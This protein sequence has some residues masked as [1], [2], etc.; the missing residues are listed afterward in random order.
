MEDQQIK[1]T[2][3]PVLFA[4]CLFLSACAHRVPPAGITGTGFIDINTFCKKHNFQYSLDT[5]NDKVKLF[6][7]GR[8]I[9]LF[10]NSLAGYFNGNV[11]Y[12]EKAPL[13]SQ[14]K[15]YLPLEL[16]DI[17][18]SGGEIS[19]PKAQFAI[20]TV[21]VDPGHG[22]R[23]PGAVSR[24]GCK[25]KDIN[26]QVS[27]Y[28]KEEL[29]KKG[30]NVILTRSKDIY[31]TLEER[32]EI[33]KKHKADIFI[34]IHANSNRSRS[35]K[36]TEVYYLSPSQ[37]DSQKRAVSLAKTTNLWE[38]SLPLEVRTILWDLCLT[39]NYT[40]S[41][42]LSQ[43]L[44]STF[45]NLGFNVKQ[46]KKAAF[47]VLKNAYVPS[48]LVEMGYLSNTYEE[49]TLRQ[50]HYQKKIAQAVAIG[51]ASLNKRYTVVSKKK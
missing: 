51:A 48:I 50:K 29:E 46:P 47:Y 24:R 8:E 23:D 32:V 19:I 35:I 7:K 11:F 20:R 42:E 21:V 17:I 15:I 4:L 26:L 43:V 36:G 14:G 16:E 34:S 18:I 41:V 37:F 13:Y 2:I 6:S 22:G 3:F 45:K 31:L 33:A 38:I 30:F 28:L 12:L 39:K 1:F 10:F 49:K 9:F 40:L 5:D 27:K 25:E 44:F